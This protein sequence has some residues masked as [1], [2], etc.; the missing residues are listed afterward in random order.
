MVGVSPF[1]DFS[2][3]GDLDLLV[4]LVLEVVDLATGIII[5]PVTWLR[6]FYGFPKC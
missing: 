5:R 6:W 1:E 3:L 4:A 2:D